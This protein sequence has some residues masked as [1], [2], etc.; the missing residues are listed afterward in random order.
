MTTNNDDLLA[1]MHAAYQ[2]PKS[3]LTDI[4][5]SN[6]DAIRLWAAHG[7]P[8]TA[9]CAA[10]KKRGYD[11]NQSSLRKTVVAIAGRN[12]KAFQKAE[13]IKL[14]ASNGKPTF[15]PMA[16]SS[17]PTEFGGQSNG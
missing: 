9:V 13:A 10:L 8:F 7:Y 1:E 12:W 3:A 2:P 15:A 17:F 11:F 6:F 4:A 16:D 14:A 5:E